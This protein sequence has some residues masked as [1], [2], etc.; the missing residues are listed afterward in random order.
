[1]KIMNLSFADSAGAAYTLAHALNKEPNIQA[2]NLRANNNYIDYPTI[3]EMRYYS[4]E[5][6]REMVYGSD[7][8]V[9][10]TAVQPFF[11]GLHLDKNRIKGKR[12][13]LYFHGSDARTY[14]KAII[15]QADDLLGTGGYE[16]LVSTPDLLE[17]LPQAQW[18]PVARS[19]TE[20]RMRYGLDNRD[21]RALAAFKGGIKKTIVSH[22]P[23]SQER[24]GSAL[25]YMVITEMIQA[26]PQVEYQVIQQMTW[27][28]AQRAMSR[29]SIFFDQHLLGA[30]G[31]AGVEA[32]IFK[33]AVFCKLKPSV[34]EAMEKQTGQKNPFIQWDTDDELRQQAFT[35]VTDKKLRDKFGQMAYDY[36][37]AVHDEA[38]VA[39]KFLK[40]VEAMG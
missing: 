11:T 39:A 33:A 22:A 23:T 7:V 35:L 37:K 4:E 9:L 18:M 24:K 5:A 31:L 16:V 21:A 26:F 3:S 19:F 8:L 29:V 30:Y 28:Q 20:T 15:K 12:V 38:P 36:S 13:L 27:D 1:M 25:F 32:S 6:A 34:I 10:H 14:G 40:I 17:L 2:I